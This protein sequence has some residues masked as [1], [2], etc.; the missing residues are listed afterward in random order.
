MSSTRIIENEK[1]EQRAM[2][3]D[4]LESNEIF[5]RKYYSP[6][7]TDVPYTLDKS[8]KIYKGRYPVAECMEREVITLPLNTHMRVEY[9]ERICDVVLKTECK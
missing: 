9:M 4:R 1:Q 2:V 7:M 3:F 6:L 8:S 5:A